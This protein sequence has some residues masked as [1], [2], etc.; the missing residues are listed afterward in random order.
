MIHSVEAMDISRSLLWTVLVI[1]LAANTVISIAGGATWV[2]LT[3]GAVTLV[4]AAAL[5]ALALRDR[6]AR[7]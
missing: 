7:P 6:R 5:T 3:S 2:H 1:S 4:A